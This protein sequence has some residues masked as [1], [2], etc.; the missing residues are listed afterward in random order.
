M[1]ATQIIGTLPPELQPDTLEQELSD[2][3]QALEVIS[4]ERTRVGGIGTA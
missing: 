2:E 3:T 4:W 1:R